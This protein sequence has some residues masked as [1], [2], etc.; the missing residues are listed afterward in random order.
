MMKMIQTAMPDNSVKR[1]GDTRRN[2]INE[3]QNIN[4][5]GQIAFPCNEN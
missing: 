1:G 2:V 5:R 3:L 4:A